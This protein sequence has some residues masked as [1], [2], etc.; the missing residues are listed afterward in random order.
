MQQSMVFTS[1]AL[2][3]GNEVDLRSAANQA[4]ATLFNLI[5]FQNVVFIGN[6]TFAGAVRASSKLV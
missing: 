5:A 1:A 2:S 3:A 6:D 4:N